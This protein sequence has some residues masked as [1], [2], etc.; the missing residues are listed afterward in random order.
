MRVRVCESYCLAQE[1]SHT[2][3]CSPIACVYLLCACAFFVCHQVRNE[4]SQ[5]AENLHEEVAQR[6]QLSEEF[7]QVAAIVNMQYYF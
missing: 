1:C 7:E 4:L 2:H 5:S 3:V 6:Q